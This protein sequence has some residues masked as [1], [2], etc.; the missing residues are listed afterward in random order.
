[1]NAANLAKSER[2]QRVKKFLSDH[3]PHSTLEIVKKAN[4]CAVN[5]IVSELRANGLP[6]QCKRRADRWYYTLERA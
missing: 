4:V 6:I 2:L 1:M 3:R 5:S